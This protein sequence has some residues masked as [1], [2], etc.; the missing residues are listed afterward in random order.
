MKSRQHRAS[1]R[2]VVALLSAGILGTSA[3]RAFADDLPWS[4]QPAAAPQL[5]TVGCADAGAALS[6]VPEASREAVGR[7][8]AELD[9]QV[10]DA[11]S[12]LSAPGSG[13]TEGSV[14]AALADR[15]AQ[16]LKKLSESA[17]LG[18]GL[19]KDLSGTATCVVRHDRVVEESAKVYSADGEGG[20][21]ARTKA[22]AQSDYLPKSGFVDIYHVPPNAAA[23]LPKGSATGSFRSR[24]GRNEDRHLNSDNVIVAP[25]VSNGAHHTH[26]YVGNVATDAV[27][28]DSVLAA[29]GTTCSNGDRSAYFWPV[30]RVLDGTDD[31]G[32]P[33][34]S[35]DRNVGRILVPVEVDITYTSRVGNPVQPMARF[36]RIITGDPKAFTTGSA[37]VRASWSCTGLENRQVVG[38]YPICPQGSRVLRTLKFPDC[39]DGRNID[40]ANHRTHTAFSE[41]TGACPKDFKAIPQLVERIAYDVP[42]G[43]R[44]AVDSFP[45]Q[46]HNPITDHGYFVNNMNDSL[47]EQMTSC[48]N[49]GRRCE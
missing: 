3:V 30:L 37:N 19:P 14:L 15:R 42:A 21:V 27:S 28:S 29:S 4:G 1:K 10:A 38:R 47:L 49:Q 36:L 17:G 16:T 20:A 13:D 35:L 22:P 44:Y 48:V 45:E 25:G 43:L 33:G 24:C 39:W 34:G 12:R 40:S 9:S 31:P 8:L 32:S 7:A 18:S 46:L 11:Y 41:A 6:D 23:P 26:D 2:R 5:G